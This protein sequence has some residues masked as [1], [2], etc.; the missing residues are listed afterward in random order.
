MRIAMITIAAA[1]ITAPA[2][3][4]N[5]DSKGGQAGHQQQAG[6]NARLHDIRRTAEDV[7]R[8]V[9]IVP[10]G[11]SAEQPAVVYF[12]SSAE[13][14]ARA[15]APVK[16]ERVDEAAR[17][18]AHAKYEAEKRRS[19]TANAS[20]TPNARLNEHPLLVESR[21]SGQSRGEISWTTQSAEGPKS[22]HEVR[23]AAL[24]RA[25]ADVSW[26]GPTDEGAKSPEEARA[27]V[28][29]RTARLNAYERSVTTSDAVVARDSAI[30]GLSDAA[31]ARAIL[32]E[33]R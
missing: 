3:G 24:D 5:T 17:A 32:S 2:Y 21:P 20:L 29:E 1:L 18:R 4:E 10:I 6:S 22:A 16:F 23:T 26:Q 30:A 12:P 11:R 13:A 27:A 14:A 25:R 31:R 19:G 9:Q 28:L 7:S 33:L 15:P 8:S